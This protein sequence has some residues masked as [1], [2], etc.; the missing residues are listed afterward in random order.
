MVRKRLIAWG[1][2]LSGL[3]L[4]PACGR[5]PKPPEVIRSQGP[6][7]L[8]LLIEREDGA[9]PYVESTVERFRVTTSGETLKSVRWSANAGAL[10]PAADQVSWKLPQAGTASL[11]VSVET[12]SGK[13]AEGAVHFNVV[14][15]PLASSAVIDSGPDVTG[16]GCDLA[17]DSTGK[18]HVVYTNE[19][20]NSLWYASWDGTA[21]KTEQIEGPGFNNG[22]VFVVKGVLA[23]DPVTGTPHVA[24]TKG[25]G[26]IATASTRVGYATRVNGVWVREEVD[27]SVV[28]R[29]S[30]ALNPAQA[31]RPVIVFSS[32][33]AGIVRVATRTAA[34]TW[35]TVPLTAN[36]QVLTSDALFDAAGALHVIT[37]VPSSGYVSQSLQV[38]RGSTLESFPLKTST[39]A[40]WLA[41]AWAP[42]SRLLALS[43]SISDGEWNAIEDI[44]VGTPAASSTR[45]V[46]TVDY[47]YAASDLA[48]GGG[49][50]VVALRNGTA[51]ALGTTDAQGFWTY[52][53]L[54][55]V[56]DSSRP[57][58][59]VHPT[60]GV[61]HVCYQRDGKVTFQ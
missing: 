56:Q 60:D 49:K 47:K 50:P 39:T 27:A 43:N 61:P 10:E 15:A 19:T 8:V 5:E 34:N 42:D 38:L 52:T 33:P 11:S 26:N 2:M 41:T 59:A 51:L 48:Y 45:R 55:T 24:Y 29:F 23:V 3:T 44:T 14:A 17:F 36:T 20:H 4:L 25:T 32:N 18:A 31:Q 30:L 1:L 57:S 35:S 9:G 21:W 16:A 40:P 22:G 12:E 28:M 58:V 53:Q 54:G 46:S 7:D 13:T 37:H 6:G